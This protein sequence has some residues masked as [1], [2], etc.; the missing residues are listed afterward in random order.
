MHRKSRV[1]IAVFLV[2]V[3]NAPMFVIMHFY[4]DLEMIIKLIAWMIYV[5]I[6]GLAIAIINRK[7]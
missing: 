6:S 2:I 5:F 3:A 4:P 7:L 1:L